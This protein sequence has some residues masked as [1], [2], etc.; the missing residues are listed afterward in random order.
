MAKSVAQLK[1]DAAGKRGRP[2]KT[3]GFKQDTRERLVWCGMEMLTEKGYASTGIDEV[4][5]MVGVPKGSFYH[6]FSSKEEFGLAV[7]EGYAVYFARKLDRWLLDETHAPLD[8]LR[9][10]V[11]DGARGVERFEFRRG[12]LIGNMGQELAGT[13]GAFREPLEAVFMDWQ[14][15]VQRCLEKAR[16]AGEIAADADCS[17]L[18]AF[19]WMGWEG[20][21]LRSK[22]V[23]S[24]DPIDL[25]A[26]TFFKTIHR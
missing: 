22:L 14:N 16:D 2:R 7:I 24:T 6:Y 8:R 17:E 20:A 12:C 21:I 10:F 4:L 5:R 13:R 23:H 18:A 1:R 25:F 11:A 26:D 9:D 15:R 19:F 3:G